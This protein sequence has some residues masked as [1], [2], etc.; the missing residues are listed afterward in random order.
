MVQC[1]SA[2]RW[3]WRHE[4]ELYVWLLIQARLVLHAHLPRMDAG[5]ACMRGRCHLTRFI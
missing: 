4:Q 2:K 1:D 5:L 3:K